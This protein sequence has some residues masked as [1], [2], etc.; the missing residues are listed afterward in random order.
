M[1]ELINELEER[2]QQAKTCFS[3]LRNMNKSGACSNKK[4]ELAEERLNALQEAMKII[5]S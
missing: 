1:K 4:V 5:K 2:I 3:Y